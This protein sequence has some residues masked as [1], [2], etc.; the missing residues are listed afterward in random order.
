MFRQNDAPPSQSTQP[1]IQAHLKAEYDYRPYGHGS[2]ED[3]V[4]VILLEGRQ[5][6]LVTQRILEEQELESLEKAKVKQ[7]E[8][9][10]GWKFTSDTAGKMCLKVQDKDINTLIE[11]NNFVRDYKKA[12]RADPRADMRKKGAP[13]FS[14]HA[15]LTTDKKAQHLKRLAVLLASKNKYAQ[16]WSIRDLPDEWFKIDNAILCSKEEQEVLL[17]EAEKKKKVLDKSNVSKV[18]VGWKSERRAPVDGIEKKG[19][20][21]VDKPK[22][23][24]VEIDGKLR[25]EHLA[26]IDEPEKKKKAPERSRN[27]NVESDGKSKDPRRVPID[28]EVKRKKRSPFGSSRNGKVEVDG[29]TPRQQHRLPV[30]EVDKQRKGGEK[31]KNG[32]GEVDGA[33]PR[34]QHRL[35]M[36]EAEEKKTGGEKSK[37]C[38]PEIDGKFRDDNMLSKKRHGSQ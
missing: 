34:Q 2:N 33:T 23:N 3:K 21:V 17:R 10:N 9:E 29:P 25:D 11:C 13:A 12:T 7:L 14:S 35:Q 1:D 37:N 28:D 8:E 32:K 26:Q 15:L 24:K 30:N 36:N 5:K 6:D 22:N 18:E 27:A 20:P 19:K 4:A 31:L 16:Y 38:K